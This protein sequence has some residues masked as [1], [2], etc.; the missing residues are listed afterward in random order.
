MAFIEVPNF[1]DEQKKIM[2]INSKKC[3]I[4]IRDICT[5]VQNCIEEI[6]SMHTRLLI[7][8]DHL[9]EVHPNEWFNNPSEG[10]RDDR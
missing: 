5:N 6:E 10:I 4:Q 7:I 1:T 8:R 9:K 3:R 2:A